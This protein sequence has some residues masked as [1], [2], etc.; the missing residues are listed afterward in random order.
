MSVGAEA[1]VRVSRSGST[2]GGGAE[3]QVE[4]ADRLALV[5]GKARIVLESDGTITIEGG[6]LAVKGSD[7]I[8]MKAPK[9]KEN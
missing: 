3:V 7:R 9:I 6:A 8:I 5:C 4:A 2:S 1:T